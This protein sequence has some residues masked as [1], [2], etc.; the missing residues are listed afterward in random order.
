MV[1]GLIEAIG[2]A[3]FI[4]FRLLIIITTLLSFSYYYRLNFAILKLCIILFCFQVA[5]SEYFH[6]HRGNHESAKTT[7]SYGFKIEVFLLLLLF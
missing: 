4:I 5:Y 6:L 3:R 1:I 7:F 2:G